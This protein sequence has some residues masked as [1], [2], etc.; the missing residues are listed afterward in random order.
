MKKLIGTLVLGIFC[1]VSFSQKTFQ[2]SGKITDD[3]SGVGLEGA[4]VAV[5]NSSLTGFT[6][7]AGFF[8]IANLS[9]GKYVIVI[10]YTGYETSELP[11]VIK[12][13]DVL[14]FNIKL[15][16]RYTTGN[17]IVVSASKR[18]EK[19][20]DA[21]ASIQVIGR[22]ELDQFAGSNIFE[23]FSKVQGV[24]VIRFG[25][26]GYRV[27]ARGMS[28]IL[29]SNKI[30]QMIDGRNSMFAASPGPM[31]GNNATVN[32]EDLDRVEIL[33]GPQSALY[34]PNVNNMLMNF[35]TKDPRKYPGLSVALS[36]GN[37]S[38]YSARFR[39]AEKV[40]DKWAFKLTG[41]Y[42]TG[43]N[44]DFQDSVRVGGG[45]FGPS[46]AV[47]EIIDPN[48]SHLRGEAH[49]YYTIAAKSDIIVTAGCSKNDFFI[50]QAGGHSTLRD[51]YNSFLQ[52]RFNSPRL[53][54]NVYNTWINSGHTLDISGYTR[55]LWN[56]THSTITDPS[57]PN[58]LLDYYAADIYGRRL[59]NQ[60]K[61]NNQ[62][63][64]AE[65]QYNYPFEKAG[66][67]M[68]T[69]V[70]TQL[71][72]PHAYGNTLVDS[73]QSIKINQ[74]GVVLQLEKTLPWNLRLVAAGRYDH[75][76]SYGDFVSPKFAVTKKLG[77]GSFRVSWAQAY[78]MPSITMQYG[79][80]GGAL[81][82]NLKGI[83]YIPNGTKEGEDLQKVTAP[84]KVEK[85]NA[86]EFGYKGAITQKLFADVAVYRSKSK[87]LFTPFIEIEGRALYVGGI[88]VSPTFPGYYDP[89]TGELQD[90]GFGTFF[91]FGNVLIHGTD[92]GL[93]YDFN[94]WTNLSLK[95]SWVASDLAKGK[96]ENDANQDG[97]VAVDE[98]SLNTPSHRISAS[99]NFQE[100]CKQRL[101]IGLS[102]RYVA[103][104]DFYS[105]RQMSTA[106]GEG[107]WGV[108]YGG[109]DKLGTP[110]YYQKNF[111]W[112]P[113]GGFTSL[114]LSGLYKFNSTTS[115]GL[116]ITNVLDTK[117]RE[118]PGSPLIGRLIMFELR[119]TVPN[120]K[121]EL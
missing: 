65:I 109:L 91:N 117:Q 61:E 32:K 111:D 86:I 75:H 67:Q 20:T 21:P 97:Y 23:L 42:T 10:T 29:V 39:Y 104:Y 26:D 40:N 30:F 69:G 72:R 59:K 56:R 89:V 120:R 18:P 33:V 46:L 121:K 76:T 7:A 90:A 25:V 50:I 43:K 8:N 87:N 77:Q 6:D 78:T 47:P 53:H 74:F 37:Q 92:I 54:V 22:K 9:P 102:I 107:T 108:I 44:F 5:R 118:A 64:N 103:R 17:D 52:A 57:N 105:G 115:L 85:I 66:L 94:K 35:I 119:V 28:S 51:M 58:H 96:I 84:L 3:E 113:L 55:D 62:R 100:L 63:F 45:P 36:A 13:A 16:V 15:H 70:S 83:T 31:L 12:D 60:L 80:N 14:Y 82:G 38:Q 110:R 81:F 88:P 27:N 101:S 34:G 79:S 1:S 95:Y 19:I 116:N 98:K 71:D 4:T 73:F 93:N 106:S 99:I 11:V 24:E 112:G 49:A 48:F 68:I 41:E 2:V 114:D